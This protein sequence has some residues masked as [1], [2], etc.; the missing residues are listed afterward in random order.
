MDLVLRLVQWRKA[1]GMSRKSRIC[2]GLEPGLPSK[3]WHAEGDA[4]C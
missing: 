3:D 2:M 1:A 4:Q